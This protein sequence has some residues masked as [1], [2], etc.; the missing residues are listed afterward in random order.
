MNLPV[1][2]WHWADF[3]RLSNSSCLNHKYLWLCLQS[4]RFKAM[5]E[6]YKDYG[7]VVLGFPTVD[8][9]SGIRKQNQPAFHLTGWLVQ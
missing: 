2:N 5:L 8:F 6:K 3:S 9:K 1:H 7:L 4:Q